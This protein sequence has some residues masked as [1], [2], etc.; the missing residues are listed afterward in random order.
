MNPEKR[1]CADS[2]ANSMKTLGTNIERNER[3]Y[4]GRPALVYGQRRITYAEYARRARRLA[5][6]LHRRGLRR[7]DRYSVLAMNCPEFVECYAAA[8]WAGYLIATINFRLAAPEIA[9]M[10]EDAA[11]RLLFFEAQYAELVAQLRPQIQ[12]VE[13]FICIGD[14]PPAVGAWAESYDHFIAEGDDAGPPF[15]AEP[16][17]YLYLVYT[18]GTTGKAKGV[19]HR[20]PS[21]LRIA[22]VLSSELKLDAS[23][24]LLAIAPMFHM[25]VRTLALAAHF[26]GGCVVLHRSFDAQA[27]NA[28]IEQER[29]SA[30]HLVPTMVQAI[31]DAP[32]FGDSDHSSLKMLMYAAAPMPTPVLRRAVEAF[33]PITYNGYGQTEI[34]GLTFLYPHQHELDGDSEQGRR[35]GSVGQPHWQAALKIVD[36]AGQTLAAGEVGEVCARSETAM[37]GYWN[38]TR[39]T[40]E[41]V[42]D[43]W[44]YTGDMG[45][46]DDEGYLYLVDRK[47]DMII[48]GG[49]NIYSREV[50]EALAA[51]PDVY[52][53]AVLGV[54]DAYWGESVK[55]VVVLKAGSRLHPEALIAHCKTRIAS[56]KCPKSVDIVAELPRLATGKINKVELRERFGRPPA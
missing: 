46:L 39:A 17:D 51:H 3:L 19:V 29:I 43:G 50:E 33:G 5:S 9:Y 42:R 48:S 22:E 16:D 36:D 18:S 8:E 27:V 14:L 4:P 28:T 40:L 15:R 30:V 25:G 2:A 32:N 21:C 55:A 54:P 35:L 41:T 56:Y 37:A 13:H 23:D 34:N 26:R 20:H 7:Q 1:H 12:G 47:K 38:N 49:E 45:Y 24:R 52:E 6:A 10:I 11:P 53:T 44:V 31:L